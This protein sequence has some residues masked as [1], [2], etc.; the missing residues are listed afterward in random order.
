ASCQYLRTFS[1]SHLPGPLGNRSCVAA[2]IVNATNTAATPTT[3]IDL[4]IIGLRL[5]QLLDPDV[6]D[7]DLGRRF[8]LD[9]E[10]SRLVV[11]RRGV[12]VDHRRHQLAVH[13]VEKRAAARDD[14]VLIPVVDANQRA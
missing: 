11:R 5:V 12:V 6:A 2:Q 1:T 7:E 10:Q 13:D 8:D 9:A 3:N 4:W 14:G